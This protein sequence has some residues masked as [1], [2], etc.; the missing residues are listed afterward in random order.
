MRRLAFGLLWAVA[1]CSSDPASP[2]A[3]AA[4]DKPDAPPPRDP[5]VDTS[6]PPA[7]PPSDQLPCPKSP[8]TARPILF[9]HGHTGGIV[10]G[11][12]MF[13]AMKKDGERF[14]DWRSVGTKDHQAWGAKSI[15]R[16]SWA[17]NFDYYLEH[18]DDKQGTYTAGTGRV[19]SD[20]K[21]CATEKVYDEG[22]DHDFSKQLA[23]FVESVI[24]AT[25]MT[26]VDIV[27]HS[28]GGLVTRS[29][30]TFLGGAEKVHTALFMTTPHLGV[31]F[32]SGEATFN[33]YDKPWMTAHELAELDRTTLLAPTKFNDC[34][35]TKTDTWP[36]LLL[37][38]EKKIAKAPGTAGGPT[39]FCI[40][41]DKDQIVD[42]ASAQ[43]PACAT[44][45]KVPGVG[46]GDLPYTKE[47]TAYAQ[48]NVGGFVTTSTK[49]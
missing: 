6:E 12:T 10:D 45:E 34:K 20:G 22:S 26:Q 14:D 21:I 40:R 17:F 25:G 11:R 5:V 44:L 18:G 36:N 28:M 29:F 8:C 31:S 16:R 35:G 46:H 1:A 24:R 32:A 4:V 39:F 33:K 37:A 43:H 15:P 2:P 38:A 9:L 41:G 48:R 49:L 13:D 3:P 19:G 30:T 42:D 7:P 47:A 27:A 23:E